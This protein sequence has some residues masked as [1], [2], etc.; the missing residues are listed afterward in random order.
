[1]ILPL[2]FPSRTPVR[3]LLALCGATFGL[4]LGLVVLVPIPAQAFEGGP[5]EDVAVPSGSTVTEAHTA[6]GDITVDGKVEGDVRAGMGDVEVN[7][8]VGGELHAGKGDVSIRGPVGD[9]VTAGFGDV[10]VG[11]RVGGDVSV[12]HGDVELGSGARIAGDLECGNCEIRGNKGAVEGTLLSRTSSDFDDGPGGRFGF[13]GWAFA[14][15]GFAACCLL[16]SVLAPGPLSAAARRAEESPGMSFL[17]G[18]ASL[19]AA[20]VLAVAL[21][22]SVV[23]I[24]VLLLLAPAYLALVF[25]GALVAAFSLG[26]KAMLATGRHRAGNALAAVVGAL[27]VAATTLIPFAGGLLLYA[28]ALFGT[29]AIILALLARRGRKPVETHASYEDYVSDRRA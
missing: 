7:G 28:L 29:G 3:A 21:A 1:M 4:V 2:P 16:A 10:Y 6:M 23:G 11:N 9:D 27:I 5:L 15:L 20:V 22:F 17:C 18:V 24:P 19:P 14:A 13:L 26:R 12:G 8:E 25:C